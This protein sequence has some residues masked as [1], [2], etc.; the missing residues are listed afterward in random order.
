MTIWGGE[1]VSIIF[2]RTHEYYSLKHRDVIYG[3]PL[4]ECVIGGLTI[5]SVLASSLMLRWTSTSVFTS[6]FTSKLTS[7]PKTWK[8]PYF[9]MM[10][11]KSTKS[12]KLISMSFLHVSRIEKKMSKNCPNKSYLTICEKKTLYRVIFYIYFYIYYFLFYFIYISSDISRTS[13]PNC[14]KF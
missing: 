2:H 4:K 14:L 5:P 3:W 13:A 9:K 10:Q 8:N 1:K 11:R 6:V 7:R 12:F